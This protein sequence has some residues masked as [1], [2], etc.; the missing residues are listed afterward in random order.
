[1]DSQQGEVYRTPALGSTSCRLLTENSA[2]WYLFGHFVGV[3]HIV[4]GREELS[5]SLPGHTGT[6]ALYAR[7]RQGS[8]E[9]QYNPGLFYLQ[10]DGRLW[11]CLARARG[12]AVSTDRAPSSSVELQWAIHRPPLFTSVALPVSRQEET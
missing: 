11:S 10:K 6:L 7:L 5:K 2:N 9:E 1:M 8:L 3:L 12:Q 4:E